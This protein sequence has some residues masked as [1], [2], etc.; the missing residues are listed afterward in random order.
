MTDEVDEIDYD[1]LSPTCEL[2]PG[3]NALNSFDADAFA[4]SSP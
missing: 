4:E 2:E 3:V 1:Q